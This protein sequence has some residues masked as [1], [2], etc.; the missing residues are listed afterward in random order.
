MPPITRKKVLLVEDDETTYKV[1]TVILEKGGFE[2]FHAMAGGKALDIAAQQ[3]PSLILLDL[4]LPGFSGLDLL[5][6]LKK[7]PDTAAIPVVILSQLSDQ[8]SISRGIALG[9]MGYLVKSEYQLE[10]ILQK[11]KEILK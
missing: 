7:N 3:K 9:A 8:D 11:V 1:L 6:T 2:V 5:A 10:D 4:I